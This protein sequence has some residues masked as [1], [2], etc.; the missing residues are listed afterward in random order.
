MLIYPKYFTFVKI[1][2]L[3][4]FSNLFIY[5][6]CI[7]KNLPGLLLP[8]PALPL[9]ASIDLLLD[10][11]RFLSGSPNKFSSTT[12]VRDRRRYVSYLHDLGR[13]RRAY[14]PVVGAGPPRDG[15]PPPWS[16]SCCRCCRAAI[17]R[18]V[19]AVG[20]EGNKIIKM[21]FFLT[22]K[23]RVFLPLFSKRAASH[24]QTAL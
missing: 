11:S 8:P 5:S 17:N 20:W 4:L 2:L 6:R 24:N 21:C 16:A 15:P 22:A 10:M 1:V 7:R 9:M 23:L 12:E 19:E 13:R 18:A 3:T 14:I